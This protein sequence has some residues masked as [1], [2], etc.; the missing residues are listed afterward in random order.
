MGEGDERVMATEFSTHRDGPHR[1]TGWLDAEWPSAW[2]LCMVVQPTFDELYRRGIDTE[3]LA[4]WVGRMYDAEWA[5]SDGDEDTYHEATSVLDA[6]E[7]KWL[8]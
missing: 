5:L 6:I 1:T 3:A 4:Q 8:A 7:Q 2:R